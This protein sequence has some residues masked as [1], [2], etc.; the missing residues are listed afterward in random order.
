MDDHAARV[1][2][3]DF[4]GLR[5]HTE[6]LFPNDLL[7]LPGASVVP[8]AVAAAVDGLGARDRADECALG[9][10]QVTPDPLRV[11]EARVRRGG[12]RELAQDASEEDV[13]VAEEGP[14]VTGLGRAIDTVPMKLSP[15]VV[16]QMGMLQVPLAF[17]LCVGKGRRFSSV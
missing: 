6:E 1:A 11:T 17:D 7:E 8:L 4:S 5:V 9:E 3:E 14:F 15:G 10:R 12:D 2:P 16:K 13:I